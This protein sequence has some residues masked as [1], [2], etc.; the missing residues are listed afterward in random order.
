LKRKILR[1]EYKYFLNHFEYLTLKSRLKF[2]PKDPY[3]NKNG[4]YTVKSLYFEDLCGNS[5][6]E[7]NSGLLKRNKFRIRMYN[8]SHDFVVLENKIKSGKFIQK[9]SKVISKSFASKLINY[10]NLFNKTVRDEFTE[11]NNRTY[12]RYYKPK[13]IVEYKREAYSIKN[14]NNLRINFDTSITASFDKSHFFKD[15]IQTNQITNSKQIVL[16][17]KFT[18]Y[19]PQYIKILLN[20]ANTSLTSFSKYEKSLSIIN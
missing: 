2:L 13:V 16:E 9:N 6:F 11:I 12:I 14:S 15:F 1:H 18:N 7:K 4:F 20:S 19:L 5:L 10:S 3:C 8:N 17:I